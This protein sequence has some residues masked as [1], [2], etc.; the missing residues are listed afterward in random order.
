[1]LLWIALGILGVAL[2]V[3]VFTN[4]SGVVGS[5]ASGDFAQLM[6]LAALTLVIGA[7]VVGS[8]RRRT[9]TAVKHALVWVAIA[10]GLVLVYAVREDASAVG[11]RILSELVPG[12]AISRYEEGPVAELRRRG[13]G[14]FAARAVIDGTPVTLLVD[15]GA[16]AVTLTAEDAR[17]I[18]L[19]LGEVSY[20][21]P[22]TTANGRTTAARARLKQIE[23]GNLVVEDVPALVGRPGSLSESLLGISFLR[24]LRSY[25]VIGDTLVLRGE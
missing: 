1:M 21:V 19:K 17:A 24:K 7:F 5:L 16:S 4:D 14:H 2:A 15:T 20:T 8:Y 22:V 23:I 13:D 9:G 6:Q 25:E 11:A 12:Y 10:L 3:L 18:G